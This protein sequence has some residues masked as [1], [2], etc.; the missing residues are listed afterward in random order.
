MPQTK[1]NPETK[2]TTLT[3]HTHQPCETPLLKVI[4]HHAHQTYTVTITTPSDLQ[5]QEGRY[6]Q[7]AKGPSNQNP[8]TSKSQNQGRT[9][10]CMKIMPMAQP[11]HRIQI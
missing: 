1:E 2:S 8:I 3:Y 4:G 6:V 9:R 7:H 11:Q 5:E 10:T